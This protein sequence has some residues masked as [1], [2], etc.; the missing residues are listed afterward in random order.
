[1]NR[2]YFAFV[3]S[4]EC[5]IQAATVAKQRRDSERSEAFFFR[6]RYLDRQSQW[7]VLSSNE[8]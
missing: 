7:A 4:D 6:A 1:M 2:S 5:T 3:G 8:D